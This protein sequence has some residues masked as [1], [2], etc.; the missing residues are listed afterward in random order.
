[1]NLVVLPSRQGS[2]LRMKVKKRLMLSS[3]FTQILSVLSLVT[4]LPVTGTSLVLQISIQ[5]I[6]G[7]YC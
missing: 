7:Q 3:M 5:I 6:L 4:R 1:M 2:L